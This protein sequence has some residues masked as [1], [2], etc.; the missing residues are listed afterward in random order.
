MSFIGSEE[1]KQDRTGLKQEI[2]NRLNLQSV[3][4]KEVPQVDN[5]SIP[6]K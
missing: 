3:E 4:N 1:S 5:H 2:K 6:E